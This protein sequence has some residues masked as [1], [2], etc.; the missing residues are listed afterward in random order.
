MQCV[1]KNNKSTIIISDYAPHQPRGPE[2]VGS[3][4]R[5]YYNSIGRDANPVDAFWTGISRL[6]RKWTEAG[7]SVVLL[8]DWN[9][10]VRGEKTQK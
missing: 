5:R 10:D 4:Y 6:V 9:A 2:A 8:A 1:R 3:Q 7:K